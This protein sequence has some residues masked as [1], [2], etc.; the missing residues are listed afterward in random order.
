MATRRRDFLLGALAAAASSSASAEDVIVLRR[1]RRADEDELWYSLTQRGPAVPN[2]APATIPFGNGKVVLHAPVGR[3]SARLVVF[4]HGALADPLVYRPLL[5]HWVSHGFAVA[6]PVHDD[7]ILERGLLTRRTTGVGSAVWEVD[8]VLND[9]LAWDARAEGCRIP[10][11]H[12]DLL[13]KAVGIEIVADRPIIIGHEFG[14][15]VAQLLA[16][17]T[18]T[19]QNGK[20]LSFADPR[21]H[22]AGLLSAQGAG[23]MG[24]TEGSWNAV[25]KPLLVVQAGRETD[26][27]GQNPDAKIDAFR[28]SPAGYKHLGWVGD[29]TRDLYT[30]Q[31]EGNRRAIETALYEDLKAMTTAF[32]LSYAGRDETI[33][34]QFA[35]DWP[36]R[37][38]QHRVTVRH[39]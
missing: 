25:N 39:K 10:L 15:Y 35:S 27:T 3:K 20:V 1:R 8:R 19:D 17:A 28:R 14:A 29:A 16:G 6:A 2:E 30:G 13:S 34:R 32:L 37:A 9:A 24:L 31:I 12:P 4:S 22:G 36:E 23:V 33:Y 18:A 26:F 38:S 5:Q 21:W 11:E 7:S